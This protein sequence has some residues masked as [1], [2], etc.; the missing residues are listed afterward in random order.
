MKAHACDSDDGVE[1]RS[2]GVGLWR[3]VPKAGTL[4]TAGAS[5]GR[6]EVLG[7]LHDVVAPDGAHGVVVS[8]GG[9]RQRTRRP[10]GYDELMLLIDPNLAGVA[11]TDDAQDVAEDAALV[12][13]SPSSGRFYAR[14]APDREPFTTAGDIVKRGEAVAMLEV[15]KTFNRI[16]YDG[17]EARVVRIVPNDGDDI[18][19]SDIILELEPV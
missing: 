7:V 2:P 16:Q 6:L 15:M 14:P 3:D 8:S 12:F 17:D 19:A 10:V 5:I 4:V 11:I 18:E 9:D 13:R 1:L